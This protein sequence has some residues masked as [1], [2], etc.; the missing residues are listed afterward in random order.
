MTEYMHMQKCIC[1]YKRPYCWKSK[2][3]GW[4]QNGFNNKSESKTKNKL[5]ISKVHFCIDIQML[6]FDEHVLMHVLYYFFLGGNGFVDSIYV[7]TVKIIYIYRYIVC[8]V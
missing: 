4:W 1:A 8:I 7:V 3:C 6:W 5:H 2:H